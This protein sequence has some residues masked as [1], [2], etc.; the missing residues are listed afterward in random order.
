[1]KKRPTESNAEKTQLQRIPAGCFSSWLRR[2]RYSLIMENGA[3]VDCGTCKACCTSSYFI[4]IRPEE[5]ETAKRINKKLLFP[6]PGQPKGNVLM[7]YFENGYCPMMVDDR[8]TIYAHRPI[9]C[10][11]Y[12][13]R[14]FAA[15]GILAGD[16]DK[17]LINQR[18]MEWEF[19]YPTK[20]DRSQHE[21][22][23]AA[24]RFLQEKDASFPVG[25]VPGNPSQLA[26][27]AIKIYHVFL[28]GS[29]KS[30]SAASNAEIIGA[31]MAEHDRFNALMA[32][33]QQG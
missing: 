15:A 8:C 26:L 25:A 13:C 29:G 21:A 19:V 10:R 1:M 33:K 24:A 9:T 6:A 5:T 32:K 7:G 3:V 30:G 28:N 27:M 31:V 23:L 18:V 2:A 22:V 17:A 12:D 11:S 20:L 4:H 16:A 14:I